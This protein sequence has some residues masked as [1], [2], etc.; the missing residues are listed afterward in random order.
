MI[1]V[2]VTRSYGSCVWPAPP[3]CVSVSGPPERS[4]DPPTPLWI[5][6][7]HPLL[8]FELENLRDTSIY[9]QLSSRLSPIFLGHCY[10]LTQCNYYLSATI[11]ASSTRVLRL[12]TPPSIALFTTRYH[13]F[14]ILPPLPILTT[15]RF[16]IVDTSTTIYLASVINLYP[17]RQF[18]DRYY[19]PAPHYLSRQLP[20]S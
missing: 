8:P 7:P 3:R 10:Y 18:Y 17:Q 15:L 11:T 4:H 14:D 20:S 9:F 19:L 2:G 12:S 16:T 1:T 13:L 5:L 6:L